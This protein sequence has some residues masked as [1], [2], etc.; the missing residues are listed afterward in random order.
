MLSLLYLFTT[1]FSVSP[2]LK[3]ILNE[4][5]RQYDNNTINDDYYVLIIMITIIIISI[6]VMIT[7]AI[8]ILTEADLMAVEFG[9]MPL[10]TIDYTTVV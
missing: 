8:L 7:T 1:C 4:T 6:M 3:I 9:F 10:T 2:F 5:R